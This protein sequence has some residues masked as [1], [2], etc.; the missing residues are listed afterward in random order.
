MLTC[1]GFIIFKWIKNWIFKKFSANIDIYN[2][3][4]SSTDSQ[5]CKRVL[6]PT[7]LRIAGFGDC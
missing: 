7:S 6:R 2:L 3:N 4:K 5:S 1:G